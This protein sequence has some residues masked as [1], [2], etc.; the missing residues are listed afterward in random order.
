MISYENQP[1]EILQR[2]QNALAG[3]QNLAAF[4]SSPPLS[5]RLVKL[6]GADGEWI[7]QLDGQGLD[8][9]QKDALLSAVAQFAPSANIH[10]Y[11]KS[12][13]RN[14]PSKLAPTTVTKK[15]AFGLKRQL[16]ELPG[17]KQ[18][19]VVASGKGGVGKSTVSVNLAAALAKQGAKV[20]LL[21]ADIHGPSAPLMLGIA[22]A[23]LAVNSAQALVPQVAHGISCVSFGFLSDAMNPVIWR[24][25]MASKALLQL[26]YEVAWPELDYLVIDLPPGTGDI[27]LS[28]IENIPIDAALIVTTSQEVALIDAQKALTMFEKLKIPV[29]GVVEN[30]AGFACPCCNEI[31]EI[32]GSGGAEEFARQRETVILGK[33]P[34]TPQLPGA[35]KT[36]NL[37][38]LQEGSLVAAVFAD[39][40][41]ALRESICKKAKPAPHSF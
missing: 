13:S 21:D 2:L 15:A 8:F 16:R 3:D 18:I 23:K 39:L 34:L 38:A 27:Q 14:T 29:A 32:F 7:L 31:T 5:Q 28:L 19:I 10:A 17:V 33:I 40:A 24:G 35:G 30:M 41:N 22:E 11:F 1:D 36:G 9:S 6:D 37:M 12:P 26:C 25:P 20:G 4:P